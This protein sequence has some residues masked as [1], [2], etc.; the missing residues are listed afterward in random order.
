MK[1]LVAHPQRQHSFRLATALV[2]AGHDV[3]YM[4]TVYDKPVSL[5]RASKRFLRGDDRRRAEGRRCEA[6]RDGQVKLKFEFLGLVSLFL[7]RIPSKKVAY[8]KLNDWID[9][10]FGRKVAAFARRG[11]FDA[12][13]CYDQH[14]REAFRILSDTAP[15]IVRVLDVSAAIKTTQ[16]KLVLS[17]LG[18]GPSLPCSRRRQMLE[19][20]S[21]PLGDYEVEVS[22]A[23]AFLAPSSFVKESLFFAGAQEGDVHLCP[24]GSNFAPASAVRSAVASPMHFVFCGRM[25]P[26]KGIH[27]IFQ[28]FDMVDPDSFQLTLAGGYN[29]D[30][31]FFDDYLNRYDFKGLILHDQVEELYRASDVMVFPSMIEGMSLACLEALGC[32]LPI[33]LTPSSGASDFIEDYRNGIVIPPSN[34]EALRDAILWCIEHPDEVV[35]MKGEA[36]DS[37][38]SITWDAYEDAV[39]KAF[40]ALK[41]RIGRRG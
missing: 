29:N 6:L 17:D 30:D 24:Y 39:A 4:T 26:N 2:K 5:T 3:T 8:K 10:H 35:R 19:P 31:G 41:R 33:I 37:A 38:R 25:I 40:R 14:A 12:V 9:R 32:G 23:H 1:I 28:A 34:V 21:M 11:G 20:F 16:A 15:S 18:K 36:L 13:V 7:G 22:L 27:R